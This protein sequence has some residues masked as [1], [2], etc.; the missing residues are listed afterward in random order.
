MTRDELLRFLRD[1]PWAVEASVRDGGKPEAAVIG[2]AVTDRLEL[3]F[4]TQGTSRKAENL[5][6]NPRIALVVGWDHGQTAQVEGVADE[7]SGDDLARLKASYLARFPD[8]HERAAL[9]DI[10]YFRVTPTWIRYSDFRSTPPTII[11]FD[12][13]AIEPRGAER[14]SA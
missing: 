3:V 12:K 10:A 8:G 1:Q 4:D 11:V 5:R 6:A 13:G 14:A 2:V 7:P 9:G